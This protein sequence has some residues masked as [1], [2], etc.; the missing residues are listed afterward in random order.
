MDRF[1]LPDD[2]NY[3]YAKAF[4][5]KHRG[6]DIFAPRGTSVLAVADGIARA[7]EDPKGGKVVYLNATAGERYYYAH[8]DTWDPVL[9]AA[10]KLGMRVQAGTPL[11]TLGST[12]NAAGKSPHLHFQ[13][14][15][16]ANEQVDPFDPLGDVD[17]HLHP[18]E[19][20]EPA[21]PQAPASTPLP[22]P[23]DV[24]EPAPLPE[25]EPVAATGGGLVL[26]LVLWWF[27][28]GRKGKRSRRA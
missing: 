10:G 20:P 19:H 22:S 4:T 13:V 28:K 12:G 9:E 25:L 7:A 2:T 3:S 8:L 11:G 14:T 18:V 24:P 6:T 1:P 17:P 21:Q 16:A 27:L 15:N 23:D 5:A 26:L